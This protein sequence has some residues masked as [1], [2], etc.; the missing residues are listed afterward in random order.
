MICGTAVTS[1]LLHDR[2]QVSAPTTQSFLNYLLLAL[3]YC[4]VLCCRRNHDDNFY[5]I[6]LSRWWKYILV[7]LVD[8]EANYLVVKAYQYTTLTSVQVG[9]KKS[10]WPRIFCFNRQ[11]DE[12]N[13]IALLKQNTVFETGKIIHT[14]INK[15]V[16]C[17]WSTFTNKTFEVILLI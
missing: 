3:V 4:I 2:Y 12:I 5:H 10:V 11:T 1:Q 17:S 16:L 7:A 9:N 15:I 8:V 14:K 6:F 13:R